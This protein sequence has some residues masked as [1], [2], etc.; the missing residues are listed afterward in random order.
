MK[1]PKSIRNIYEDLVDPYTLLKEKMDVEL[2]YLL[3]KNWHYVS[4]IKERESFALKIESGRY[5]SVKDFDD[6]FACTIVVENIS[7]ISKAIDIVASRFE[8]VERKPKSETFTHKE[9][10]AFPFDD[11]RLYMRWRDKDGSKPSGLNELMFEIQIKTFL[12]H[13]WSIATHDLI[14]KSDE[15]NW[16]KERI[17][18]QIKAMLEHAEVS[19]SEANQLSKSS[20]LNIINKKTKKITKIIDVILKIWPPYTLPYNLKLLATNIYSILNELSMG[21]EDLK[22]IMEKENKENIGVKSV[23]LTPFGMFIQALFN[24]ETEKIEA[25]LYSEHK[26]IRVFI[27]SEIKIPKQVDASKFISYVKFED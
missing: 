18:Y 22:Q 7:N 19:I 13:A 4:R 26:Y 21:P 12:Q 17:A 11:L 24:Q 23:N 27:H 14:Y 9:P 2:K 15:I 3:S 20:Y 10:S 1:I 16:A 25:L 6:F 8:L 5:K